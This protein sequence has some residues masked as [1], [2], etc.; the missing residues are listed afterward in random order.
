MKKLCLVILRRICIDVRCNVLDVD[1]MYLCFVVCLQLAVQGAVPPPLRLLLPLLHQHRA[2]VHGQAA[3]RGG[4]A[5]GQ[6]GKGIIVA[7]YN[8]CRLI[9]TYQHVSYCRHDDNILDLF[10]LLTSHHLCL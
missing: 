8:Y 4:H 9:W 7:W 1:V 5:G 3:G 2:Q 10:G 6:R